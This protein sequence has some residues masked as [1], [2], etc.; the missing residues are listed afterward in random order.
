MTRAFDDRAAPVL[1]GLDVAG[2]NPARVRAGREALLAGFAWERLLDRH[3]RRAAAARL[4]VVW[5]CGRPV[6]CLR[7]DG[8]PVYGTAPV[9]FL[10]VLLDGSARAIAVE[11]KST[12]EGRLARGVFT[13]RQAAALDA[14]HAAGGL[15]LAAIELRGRGRWVLPWPELVARWGGPRGGASVGPEQLAGRELA[16]HPAGYLA[17]LLARG[18]R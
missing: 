16:D 11:A 14:A 10:G 5:Q 2:P 1:P 12:A 13:E 4:A 6:I 7:D 17:A 9:D 15:A 8:S 3:H 18:P